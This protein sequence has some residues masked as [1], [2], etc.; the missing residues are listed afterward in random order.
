MQIV[1]TDSNILV[2][3]PKAG[4]LAGQQ[5]AILQAEKVNHLPIT[6]AALVT[7]HTLL[8]RHII[9]RVQ[10][11]EMIV[12]EEEQMMLLFLCEK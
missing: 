1:K 12:N 10:P 2:Q 9:R 8:A 4:P 5:A 3:H 11:Q 6:S 7:L